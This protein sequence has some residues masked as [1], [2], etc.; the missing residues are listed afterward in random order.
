M[1]EPVRTPPGSEPAAP[2]ARPRRAVHIALW[3]LQV[4]TG[5]FFVFASAVPKLTASPYA[6]DTFEGMGAGAWLMYTVG[7]LELAGGIA[8][9]VPVLAALAGLCF[10]GLM[11]GAFIVQM[12]Y[13]GGENAATPVILG[14]VAAL[15][16]WG[17]RRSLG[18]LARLVGGRRR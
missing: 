13:F 9:M 17:R 11:I 18:D 8:L 7:V 15:I 6:L 14:A 2:A 4:L 16:A 3:V 1:S 10:I 5:L 12:S